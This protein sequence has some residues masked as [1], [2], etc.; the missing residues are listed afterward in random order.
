MAENV[1]TKRADQI[2]TAYCCRQD[3]SCRQLL[4]QISSDGKVTLLVNNFYLPGTMVDQETGEILSGPGIAK[5]WTQAY[6][7]KEVLSIYAMQAREKLKN[8]IGVK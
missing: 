4:K 8:W 7:R 5:H 1:D 3:G 6:T 2:L